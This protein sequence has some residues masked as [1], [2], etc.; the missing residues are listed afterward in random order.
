[1]LVQ[2]TRN[3]HCEHF[4]ILPLKRRPQEE[5]TSHE[6]RG[7]PASARVWLIGQRQVSQRLVSFVGSCGERAATLNDIGQFLR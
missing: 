1:M 3:S 4:R 6:Q 7:R 2:R 5:N